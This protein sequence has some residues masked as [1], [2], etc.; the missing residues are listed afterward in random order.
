MKSDK[1]KPGM[2]FRGFS[3]KIGE[4]DISIQRNLTPLL[5]PKEA[6]GGVTS[7]PRLRYTRHIHGDLAT[8]MGY[9]RAP[10][11]LDWTSSK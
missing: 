6:R 8:P 4:K 1:G 10:V 9:P 11:F 7:K 2:H 3:V 5:E